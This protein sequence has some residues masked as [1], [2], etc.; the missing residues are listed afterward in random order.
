MFK[1]VFILVL[2][3]GLLALP[4][5]TQAQAPAQIAAAL[6]DLSNRV[7]TTVT[8][9]N[10]SD[11]SWSE[12]LYP[13]TSL[14][15]PQVGQTYNQ[16]QTRG[17]QFLLTYAGVTYDYRV[18][19]D[20]TIVILCSSASSAESC[21][22]T[23]GSIPFMQTRLTVGQQ[24]RVVVNI[25]VTLRQDPARGS[26]A[27]ADIPPGTVLDVLD[28]PR[29][30][31]GSLIYWQV[32]Y[33]APNGQQI[34]GWAAEG[35]DGEYYLEPVGGVTVE[36]PETRVRITASNAAQLGDIIN[37]APTVYTA[38]AVSPN[39]AYL[40]TGDATGAVSVIE[41]ATGNIVFTIAGQ[42]FAVTSL[43]FTTDA[44]LLAAVSNN[45]VNVLDVAT[46]QVRATFSVPDV[47]FTVAAFSPLRA[48][49]TNTTAGIL[50]LAVGSQDGRLWIWDTGNVATPLI[51]GGQAHN[52]AVQ[53]LEFTP[54]GTALISTGVDGTVRV[55]GVT[56]LPTVE[57]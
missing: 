20:Q 53:S 57:G 32:R 27:L 30:A 15:C 4:L 26:T 22:T 48:G 44:S 29:C 1:R 24:A 11:W 33:N 37:V 18:S 46:G 35:F 28:G 42:D 50:L 10:L 21:E 49:E 8:V 39:S 6:T 12:S 9:D 7:G 5:L 47:I 36:Q 43:V 52:G 34:V 56:T 54:N 45:T 19:A 40:A 16:V 13:D 17:F 55:W 3:L 2:A 14:G 51:N 23:A 31:I 41:L 38:T 25:T